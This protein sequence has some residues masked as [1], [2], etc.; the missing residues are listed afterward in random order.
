MADGFCLKLGNLH[1]KIQLE[2]SNYGEEKN[3]GY[4]AFLG[5]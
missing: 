4:F 2:L 5:P 1:E 3:E